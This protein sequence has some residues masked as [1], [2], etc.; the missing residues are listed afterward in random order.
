ME[1]HRLPVYRLVEEGEYQ[2]NTYHVLT[3]A[4]HESV[5]EGLREAFLSAGSATHTEGDHWATYLTAEKAAKTTITA[6]VRV[7]VSPGSADA[8][9]YLGLLSDFLSSAYKFS[10][11]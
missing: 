6:D 9:D 1:G 10:R 4:E 5:P 7:A 2:G 3:R 11:K 8:A